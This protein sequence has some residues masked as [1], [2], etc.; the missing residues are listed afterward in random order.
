M[1]DNSFDTRN[2]WNRLA[3]HYEQSRTRADSLDTLVEF[4]AQ[5][6]FIGDVSGRSILDVGCGSGAKALYFAEHGA[7]KV[8]AVDISDVFIDAWKD[9]ET[10]TNLEL[11]QG[12]INALDEVELLHG[13]QFDLILCLA[14]LGYAKDRTQAFRTM[15][16]YIAPGGS[17]VLMSP[18]P[19]RFAV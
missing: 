19:I 13:R 10:P 18:S 6:E 14:V 3:P 7:A 17:I 5:I 8:T 1:N 12:D 4:P 15:A 9:R 2:S 11:A 16:R